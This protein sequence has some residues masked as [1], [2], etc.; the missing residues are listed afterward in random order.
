M[1]ASS[2]LTHILYLNTHESFS[3]K[4]HINFLFGV[5]IY[6]LIMCTGEIDLHASFFFF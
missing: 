2:L 1:I 6:T 5:S 3:T 4:A